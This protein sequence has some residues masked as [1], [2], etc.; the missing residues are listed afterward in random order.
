MSY[1]DIAP[2]Q[3]GSDTSREAAETI[4][5]RNKD[6][7]AA[8]EFIRRRGEQGATGDEVAEYLSSLNGT[9]C[10]PGTASARM[11]DLLDDK[12]IMKTDRRRK[13]RSGKSACV[14]VEAK[15]WQQIY[16][17]P[18]S[19]GMNSKKFAELYQQS[20]AP[21]PP[22]Q[23]ERLAKSGHG[24]V[25]PRLDGAK[26]GCGGINRCKTCKQEKAYY[27]AMAGKR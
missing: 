16:P 9:V 26:E 11:T 1:G 8:L 24:H 2:Y 4:K 5:G 20:P 10:A 21:Q 18:D 6:A 3:R 15:K 13:T 25:V 12:S 14:H 19:Q 23:L 22:S 7:I 27:D 17:K